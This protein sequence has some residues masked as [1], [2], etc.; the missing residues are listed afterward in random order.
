[1][2][3]LRIRHETTYDYPQPVTFGPWRLIMRPAD[4][5]ALRVIEASLTFSPTGVTRWTSDAYGNSIC[6][7]EPQGAATRLSVV[8]DL[9]IDRFPNPLLPETRDDPR[10]TTPILYDPLDVAALSPY[11]LLATDDTEAQ[12]VEW[13]KAVSVPHGALALEQL[14]RINTA[15]HTQF[16]YGAREEEGVQSP[17]E[18]VWLGRGTCRDFAWLMIESARRLGFAARFVTGYI[19]SPS[20]SHQG[21]GAT[22]AWCEVFLPGL[23]WVE[24]DPTNGLT[25]SHDLIRVAATRTPEEASPMS[26]VVLGGAR[27]TMTVSVSVDAPQSG[28][29]RTSVA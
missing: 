8:N 12:Y 25:E 19:Y 14:Q 9:L 13:L 28:G 26:G 4:S 21:A 16:S 23:G 2:Q 5:H 17:A 18:T 15:I 3:R 6:V 29:S 20:A 24:F 22:H 10:S 27:A 7:L 11:M 1:M